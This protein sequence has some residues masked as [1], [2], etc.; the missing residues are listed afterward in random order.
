MELLKTKLNKLLF[1]TDFLFYR[2]NGFSM[3]GLTYKAIPLGPVPSDYELL[4]TKLEKEEKV[5]RIE[6]AYD[7]GILGEI[8]QGIKQN[9]KYD[10]SEKENEVI[11]EVCKKF[12]D[13]TATQ[14]KDLSHKELAWIENEGERSKISYQK[15]A[16]EL[17]G[18]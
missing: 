9:E 16:F 7:N 6:K 11:N 13:F 12:R 14:I 15:Y 2:I 17:N 5:N 8:I 3:T 4:Y 18:I 10:F 1:Y